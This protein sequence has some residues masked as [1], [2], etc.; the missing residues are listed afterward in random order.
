MHSFTPVFDGAPRRADV[1]LLYDP[2][3]AA[4]RQWCGRWREALLGRRPE[5]IVRRNDP[6][7]GGA[8]GLVTHLRRRFDADRYVGVELEVNQKFTVGG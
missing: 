3:R 8:D 4:E 6:Y 5:L 2:R 1:G 7:R